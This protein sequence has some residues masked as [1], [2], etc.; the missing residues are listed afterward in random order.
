M[1]SEIA[2][3]SYT[4]ANENL[5][6]PLVLYPGHYG[7]FFA[8]QQ[9]PDSQPYFC[10]CAF[11]ALENYLNFRAAG[12][13]P[14]NA[15]PARMFIL[16]ASDFP[17]SLVEHLMNLAPVEDESIIQHLQFKDR[18]CHECNQATPSY[19]F[20]HEMYGGAF[21]QRYGWYI[22]KQA[23]E[24]GIQPISNSI[25]TEAC[26]EEVLEFIQNSQLREQEEEYGRLNLDDRM[27][28]EGQEI[29]KNLQKSRRKLWNMIENE[30]RYKFGHKKIG[31]AWTN[32]TILYYMVK[33][34][35]PYHHIHRH[36]RPHFLEGLELDVYIEDLCVGIEYQGIQHFRPVQHWGGEEALA[37][38]KSR[39]ERKRV[40]CKQNNVSLIYFR[41]DE[42]L[43]EESV[44]RKIESTKQ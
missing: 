26:P 31:E 40:L 14:Q 13:V 8:F 25:L 41:Y 27:S 15:D 43:T 39:D 10:S 35:Y 7:T 11:E 23:Y 17:R 5:P 24:W 42:T 16:D 18:L 28:E 29:E 19:R 12:P 30:V 21:K 6:L 44:Q 36:Y 34:L 38:V 22:N 33:K 4:V 9:E 3:S 20:C 32:E 1:V 37:K 2:F